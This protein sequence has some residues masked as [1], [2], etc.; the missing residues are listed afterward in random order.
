M[1]ENTVELI[2]TVE[3]IIFKSDQS[4]FCI[5]RGKSIKIESGENKSVNSYIFRGNFYQ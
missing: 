3:N 5:I 4:D 2:F 1:I